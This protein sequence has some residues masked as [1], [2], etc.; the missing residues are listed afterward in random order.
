MTL[1]A[2]LF[3]LLMHPVARVR[4]LL[5]RH[6]PCLSHS[7]PGRVISIGNLSLGG[8]G[9][10]PMTIG[11]AQ[12]LKTRGF[13]PVI[14]TRGYRSGL[15]NREA[16]VL[17][18][19]DILWS[20]TVA[21]REFRADEARLQAHTLL[22]VPVIVGIR[23]WQA[24]QSYLEHFATPT[25]WILDDGF[26]HLAIRRDVDLVLFDATSPMGESGSFVSQLQ[27]ES[28]HGLEDAT[29]IVLT[30]WLKGSEDHAFFDR[31]PSLPM[32]RVPF[33]LGQPTSI[34]GEPLDMTKEYALVC[35]IARPNRLIEDL[36]TAKINCGKVLKRADHQMFSLSELRAAAE[37]VH[38]IITTSKDYWRS[39]ELFTDL[40]TPTYILPLEAHLDQSLCGDIL[41]LL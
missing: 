39:P 19:D 8:T 35:A 4:R 27:R 10:T 22:D 9:K 2:V 41:H 30:R 5:Y 26:Q 25:H 31:L 40:A 15:K 17:K 1:G 38:G 33:I 24:A 14:L 3:H 11:I 28:L 29:G 23:R 36:K 32:G 21:G 7:L 13:S 16:V 12:Y 6:I 34:S 37:G 20:N 18:G